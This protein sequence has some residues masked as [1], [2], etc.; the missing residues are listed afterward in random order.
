MKI[1]T[2]TRACS[3]QSLPEDLITIVDHEV[4]VEVE[5]DLRTSVVTRRGEVGVKLWSRLQVEGEEGGG[6]FR[7][8]QRM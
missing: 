5:E 1:L 7:G 8:H 6:E 3:H 4:E 2:V